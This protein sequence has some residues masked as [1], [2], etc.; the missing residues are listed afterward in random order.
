MSEA[1]K[2]AWLSISAYTLLA[3][4]KVVT[5]F[6]AHSQAVLADG[7]NSVS[8][9]FLSIAI[10]IGIKVSRL[11]ADQD[12]HY[13]H[14]KAETISALI[15]ASFKGL[16][17]MNI[18]LEA[19]MAF[20]FSS[21]KVIHP[22]A[23]YLSLGS[24]ICM[25]AVSGYNFYLSKKTN[26]EALRAAAYDNRADALVSI[27]AA[28][29]VIGT[30]SGW[31]W[32]DPLAAFIIGAVVIHTAWNL[33]KPAIHTLMDGVEQSQ[34]VGMEER[35][36]QIPGVEK[37]IHLRARSQGSALFLELTVG[38]AP[39]LTVEESHRLTEQIEE[40]LLHLPHV[41]HVHVHVEPVPLGKKSNH[42]ENKGFLTGGLKIF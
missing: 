21:S 2:G 28:I 23:F 39:H 3:L 30:N 34:L 15:A 6:F 27:G 38:V 33:G 18:W 37:V 14:K 29:S 24:A 13:G 40:Q 11:P 9:I 25:F 8:D 42:S 20:F 16:V 22:I 7:M 19:I 12:H 36:L 26:S 1:Q 5:G 10:L 31:E 32:L 4:A 17:G 35:V 41:A